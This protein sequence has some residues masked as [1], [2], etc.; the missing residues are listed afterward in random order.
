MKTTLIRAGRVH[1]AVHR[2]VYV[3]DILLAGGKIT[4]IGTSFSLASSST[5]R[6]P[7][8][9]CSSVRRRLNSRAMR[10][11]VKISFA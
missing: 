10:S 7:S 9:T 8:V 3:A 2:D 6:W 4:A 5:M 1:D 11:A